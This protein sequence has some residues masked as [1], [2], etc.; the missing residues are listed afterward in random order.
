MTLEKAI[1]YLG[2]M[3]ENYDP[4]CPFDEVDAIQLAIEA[5]KLVQELRLYHNVLPNYSLPGETER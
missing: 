5:L 4:A 1:K 3:L 2:I